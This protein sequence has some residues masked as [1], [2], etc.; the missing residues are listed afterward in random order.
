MPSDNAPAR[1]RRS[2]G[3][4]DDL[5][6]IETPYG[7]RMRV[8]VL[9]E[10]LANQFGKKEASQILEEYGA[11]QTPAQANLEKNWKLLQRYDDMKEPNVSKLAH[12]LVSENIEMAKGKVPASHRHGPRGSTNVESMRRHIERWIGRREEGRQAGTWRGPGARVLL[13]RPYGTRRPLSSEKAGPDWD[14]SPWD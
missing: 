13:R 12:V 6:P 14:G 11:P 4:F 2:D 9:Y 5:P 3:L 7:A 10:A 1:R 8:R